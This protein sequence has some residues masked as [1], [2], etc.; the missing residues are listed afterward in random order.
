MIDE[1]ERLKEPIMVLSWYYS[2]IWFEG[3]RKPAGIFSED[4]LCS[5]EIETA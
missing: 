5:F 3:L 1:L 2:G 4:R